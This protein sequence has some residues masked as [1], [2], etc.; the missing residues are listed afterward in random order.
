MQNSIALAVEREL[1]RRGSALVS[2][3][4]VNELFLNYTRA[5]VAEV[6]SDIDLPK[7][8]I[9][10]VYKADPSL[11][12][13]GRERAIE[14]RHPADS[15]MAAEVLFGVGL[16]L[17]VAHFESTNHQ[18]SVIA[19]VGSPTSATNGSRCGSPPGGTAKTP[20]SATPCSPYSRSYLSNFL[21]GAGRQRCGT[22]AGKINEPWTTH[23][24]GLMKHRGSWRLRREPGPHCAPW[25]IYAFRLRI[26]AGTRSRGRKCHDRRYAV[27]LPDVSIAAE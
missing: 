7:D 10:V 21:T 13:T 15:L 9:S 1:K 11:V 27:E 2:A 23:G 16:P 3:D 5:I 25:A 6:V 26:D 19:I 18:S 8:Y 4:G 20:P 12:T 24:I 14:S 22:R 17:L